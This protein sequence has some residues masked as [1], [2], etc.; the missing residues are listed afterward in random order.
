MAAPASKNRRGRGEP[1]SEVNEPSPKR[2]ETP[3]KSTRAAAAPAA[4]TRPQARSRAGDAA[5]PPAPRP[6]RRR[7]VLAVLAAAL[8]GAA[9]GAGATFLVVRDSADPPAAAAGTPLTVSA[10]ELRERAAGMAAPVYWAGA[11]P[12]R[13]LELTSTRGGTFVRYLPGGI[14]A[15]DRRAGF[16]TIGTYP[17]RAAYATARRRG[18]Q[19]GM[20]TRETRD[21]AV[22]VWSR[23][24]PTSVYLAYR[25]VPYLI[26]VYA[27]TVAEARRLALS[28]SIRR[29]R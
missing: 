14:P 27:P 10:A 5:P 26:E 25:S 20:V 3:R 4:K 23:A 24:R 15:G 16:A 17:L 2:R 19:P 28:G 9:V 12:G 13:R 22:A 6:A 7:L 29:V 11:L 8:L 18:T 1:E 21:G